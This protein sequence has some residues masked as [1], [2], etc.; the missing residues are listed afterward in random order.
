[1][2]NN[3]SITDRY[4]SIPTTAPANATNLTTTATRHRIEHGNEEEEEAEEEEEQQ[5]QEGRKKRLDANS[6]MITGLKTNNTH[7]VCADEP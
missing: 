1:M 7:Y 5:Q 4:V 3:M 6:T 2:H